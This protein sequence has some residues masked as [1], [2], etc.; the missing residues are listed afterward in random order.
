MLYANGNIADARK[1][2]ATWLRTNIVHSVDGFSKYLTRYEAPNDDLLSKGSIGR[3]NRASCVRRIYFGDEDVK[4]V[5][6]LLSKCPNIE[7]IAASGFSLARLFRSPQPGQP[8]ALSSSAHPLHLLVTGRERHILSAERRISQTPFD[9]QATQRVTH[10]TFAQSRYPGPIQSLA[11]LSHTFPSLT[12]LSLRCPSVSFMPDA[13]IASLPNLEC[14]V[15]LG[16]TDRLVE[17]WDVL[18]SHIFRDRR[19]LYLPEVPN[20]GEQTRFAKWWD[21]DHDI[22]EEARRYTANEAAKMLRFV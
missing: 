4:A 16:T 12:H 1:F 8:S 2:R 17:R 5:P 20:E 14:L 18:M 21:D 6:A 15:Y 10:L 13:P 3:L 9:T 11:F 22:W 19:C 7:E